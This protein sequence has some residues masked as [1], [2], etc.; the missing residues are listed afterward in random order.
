MITEFIFDKVV[1]QPTTLC[2][3]N[4]SYC[5]LANRD[6]SLF[7]EQK[8]VAK[9]AES[10]ELLN[11]QYSVSIIWHGGEP[12]SCGDKR[13]KELLLPLESLEKEEKINHSIQ[14]NATLINDDWCEL[15]KKHKFKVGVSIDGPSWANTNRLNWNSTEAFSKI[16]KG[17]ECLKKH[18]IDFTVIAVVNPK[19]MRN[20]EEF[21]DFFKK[22]G[23]S[24]FG[25]NIEEYEGINLSREIIDDE[26]TT[27][28]WRELFEA[29]KKQPSV[30]IREINYVL[31]WMQEIC[32]NNVAKSVVPLDILPTI[33]YNGDVVVL[34][35]ELLG[36]KNLS[37]SD[38]IVGNILHQ[39][40]E[41]ILLDAK[42]AH[43]VNEYLSGVNKCQ[44]SC[45][46]FSFCG[47]GQAA[48]KFFELGK[49]NVMETAFCRN[50]KIRLVNGILSAL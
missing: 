6:K 10:I 7:M 42:D 47:G 1:V 16:I 40:L 12:L 37:Y 39:T 15:F 14:T 49:L 35:P 9:L 34:S 50:S 33:A 23:C 21:Y 48:N 5:Y 30:D 4:C 28:F 8:V 2:N 41:K 13:F 32:K 31:G 20:I 11:L 19:M 45:D 18:Q 26:K 24:S 17:I 29:W 44:E 3:L 27:V 25:V 38:F 46:Y 36:T 22:L 43:Y